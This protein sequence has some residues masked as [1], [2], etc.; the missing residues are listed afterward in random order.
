MTNH[1][2]THLSHSRPKTDH[3]Y[4]PHL[5]DPYQ[6]RGKWREPAS[7][8]DCGA[9]YHNGRWQWS[10]IPAHADLHRCPACARMAEGIPAAQL[11]LRG[12]FFEQCRDEILALIRHLE[13]KEKVEHPLE[14]IMAIDDI[15]DGVIVSYTGIRLPRGSGEAVYHAYHGVLSIDAGERNDL[16]RINWYR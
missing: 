11:Q 10:S 3:M 5:H 13:Q 2:H 12:D 8:P 16:M 7:C 6:T 14:R 15:E 1:A 9:V 4:E